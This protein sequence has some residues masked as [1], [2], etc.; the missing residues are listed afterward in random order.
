M[1]GPPRGGRDLGSPRTRAPIFLLLPSFFFL[2][3]FVPVAESIG[4]SIHLSNPVPAIRRFRDASPA[5][6]STR[7]RLCP[8]GRPLARQRSPLGAAPR[9]VGRTPVLDRPSPA[10]PSRP[11]GV[12]V[13]PYL[14]EYAGYGCRQCRYRTVNRS[15]MT[16]H[17]ADEHIRGRRVSRAEKAALYDDVLL[18]TWTVPSRGGAGDGQ[19][20][21]VENTLGRHLRRNRPRSLP[22][23]RRHLLSRRRRL[24]GPRWRPRRPG[25]L[26]PA[27]G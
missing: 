8:T 2:F 13:Y 10:P 16:R 25:H 6:L 18:Q 14:Y 27:A 26:E 23:P 9:P 5:V 12:P 3:S 21:I 11:D 19:Y 20:W 1:V 17:V 24:P 15:R 22:P 7:V 4:L